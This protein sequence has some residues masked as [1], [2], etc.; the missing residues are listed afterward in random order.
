MSGSVL[1]LHIPSR[2]AIFYDRGEPIGCFCPI[3]SPMA[4]AFARSRAAR[5]S[6]VPPSSAS[7]GTRFTRL[8][9]SLALRPVEWLASLADL[10]GSYFL[11]ANGDFY[12]R[13][14]HGSV[15]LPVVGYNYGGYWA[16]STGGTFTHWN[17]S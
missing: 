11:P 14:F 12:S 3:S 17:V 13:A 6:Q 9:S 15:T 1:S 10:T 8:F 5:H 4:L 2:H 16:I 7:D